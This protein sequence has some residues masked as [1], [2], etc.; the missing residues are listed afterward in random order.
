V[1]ARGAWRIPSGD[2][3]TAVCTTATCCTENRNLLTGTASTSVRGELGFAASLC[4]MGSCYWLAALQA[5][6]DIELANVEA[7]V[8]LLQS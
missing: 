6:A 4:A 2:S 1:K 3:Y 7:H 8:R 5:Q